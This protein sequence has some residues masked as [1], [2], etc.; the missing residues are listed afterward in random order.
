[1]SLTC[2]WRAGRILRLVYRSS[3]Y[4]ALSVSVTTDQQAFLQSGAF[5]G[6]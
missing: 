4:A 2:D 5:D 1:M 6:G 3:P